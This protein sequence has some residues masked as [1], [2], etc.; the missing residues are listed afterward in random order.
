MIIVTARTA[1]RLRLFIKMWRVILVL[2][3]TAVLTAGTRKGD[4]YYKEGR[5]L[6]DVQRFD[7]ALPLLEQAVEEDPQDP[8]YLLAMRRVRFQAG[9]SHVNKGNKLRKA[10]RLKEA[11]AEYRKAAAI[12]PASSIA[13]QQIRI[14][15]EMVESRR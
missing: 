8:A 6:E 12:D 9:Q 3:W 4:Q 14:T 2:L 5:A 1:R 11:L 7:E 10:G 13:Q 15:R